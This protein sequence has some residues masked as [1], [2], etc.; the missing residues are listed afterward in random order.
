MRRSVR[1]FVWGVLAFT[2]PATGCQTSATPD[3]SRSNIPPSA[4]VAVATEPAPATVVQPA[5]NVVQAG[6]AEPTILPTVVLPTAR[7]AAGTPLT[8]AS[9]EQL[10]LA[11][12]PTLVQAAAFID[13]AR[14][15]ALQAGLPLN[16]TVGITGEQIGVDRR[17]DLRTGEWTWFA[18][19]QEIVTGGKLRLSRLKYEKE[20]EL[21]E[22]Q[23]QAQRLRVVNGMAI[24]YFEVL[25]AQRAME[26]DRRLAENAAEAEKVTEQLLNLGQANQ[27]DLLQAQVEASQAKIA[28]RTAEARLRQNWIQLATMVGVP[29]LPQQPLVG[30]LEPEGP[31]LN[32][33][34]S[35]ARLLHESPELALAVGK[36]KQDQVQ[37]EREQR[38]PIPNVTVRGGVGYNYETRNQTAAVALSLPVPVFDRNQGT[39][40]QAV[41]DLS[42]AQAEVTR[43]QLDL[44][45]RFAD[46]FTQYQTSREEVENFRDQVLPKARK[47]EELYTDQFKARRAAFPQVL[48]ARRTMYQLNEAYNRSLVQYRRAEVEVRGLLLVDGLTSPPTPIPSG[49]ID[50]TAKPR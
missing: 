34:E 41:A 8:F 20:S 10:A 5:A 30:Q 19:Q 17:A 38:E 25:A 4:A 42:R 47:A 22:I 12:N 16:P 13:A 50:A 1:S 37:L 3:R 32:R 15:K 49:H 18:L 48:V 24:A 6:A 35:L 7:P 21:A 44:Q 33:D 39:V 43:V 29:D 9:L 46:V 27:Q 14:G 2:I 28:V 23:A 26:N 36:V 40:L 31:A 11:H 45:R